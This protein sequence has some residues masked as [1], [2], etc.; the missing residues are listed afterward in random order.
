M[1]KKIAKH[2]KEAGNIK[3]RIQ[4]KHIH[5]LKKKY[6]MPQIYL[7]NN[8]KNKIS[9]KKLGYRNK[10]NFLIVGPGPKGGMPSMEVDEKWK[11]FIVIKHL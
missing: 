5:M 1:K 3:I 11:N 10:A 8:L 4:K 6:R 7:K 2:E 9:L